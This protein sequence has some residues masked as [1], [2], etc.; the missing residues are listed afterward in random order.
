MTNSHLILL[1]MIGH[2]KFDQN[3]LSRFI[4]KPELTYMTDK[5]MGILVLVNCYQRCGL[6]L[7]LFWK[8]GQISTTYLFVCKKMWLPFLQ[9]YSAFVMFE[10]DCQCKR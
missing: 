3:Q 9:I 10:T 8:H 7:I 5:N 2:W 1:K 4:D 6:K